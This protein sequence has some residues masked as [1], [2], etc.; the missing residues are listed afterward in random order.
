MWLVYNAT[1]AM[2]LVLRAPDATMTIHQLIFE[3]GVAPAGLRVRLSAQARHTAITDRFDVGSGLLHITIPRRFPVEHDCQRRAAGVAVGYVRS[4]KA[5][6]LGLECENLPKSSVWEFLEGLAIATAAGEWS[7]KSKPERRTLTIWMAPRLWDAAAAARTA[8][9]RGALESAR[10]LV[11]APP[12]LQGPEQL[13]EQAATLLEPHDQVELTVY[14][15]DWLAAERFNLLRAVAA[16]GRSPVLLHARYTPRGRAR[17]YPRV[18]LVGKGVTFDS[19]GLDIKPPASMLEMKRDMAGGAAVLA[20]LQYAAVRNLPVE[21]HAVV[22]AAEN[23]VDADAMR[24]SDVYI[25]RNGLS[26]EITNTDAEGRLLLA[27]ALSWAGQTLKPDA[28]IDVAT[29]TGAATMV[30]GWHTVAVGPESELKTQL[31][32]AAMRSGERVIALPLWQEYDRELKSEIADWKNSSNTRNAGTISGGAF[33]AKFAPKNWVHLDIA[34]NAWTGSRRDY[35]P[36][37]ATGAG[38]RTL[39]YWLEQLSAR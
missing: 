28:T 6:V 7:H 8:A 1:R 23:L 35:L 3:R 39:A 20:C 36:L 32:A 5:D 27:D 34:A 13:A 38:L 2:Q 15:D 22:P 16:G 19:G 30:A 26:I 17:R 37:G 29:L 33:L 4:L 24:P 25:A 11:T 10:W 18:V 14:G 31:Q 21:L 12:N 9:L